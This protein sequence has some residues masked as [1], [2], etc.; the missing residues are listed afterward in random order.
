VDERDKS[1][2]LNA[3]ISDSKNWMDSVN[4][5]ESGILV[6]GNTNYAVGGDVVLR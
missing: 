6:E 2:T 4:W 3:G 5:N 1:G